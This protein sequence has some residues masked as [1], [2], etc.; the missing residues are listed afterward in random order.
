MKLGKLKWVIAIILTLALTLSSF[1]MAIAKEP[2][3]V[4]EAEVLITFTQRPG[5]EEIAFI[6]SIGGSVKQVYQYQDVIAA[7]VPVDELETLWTNPTVVSVEED[8]EVMILG[9]TTPWGVDMI[10][11]NL[12]HPYYQG[13]GVKVAILDT[14]ID[15]NHQDLTVAGDVT[16]V[17]D[18]TDGDDDN[19]H[20]TQVASIA[21]A[22][23]NNADSIGVAPGAHLYAVK[24]LDKDGYGKIS[25]IL[26]GIEWSITN[27]MQVINMSFGG[28]LNMPDTIITALDIAWN[29]GIVIVAGAGDAGNASGEGD[30]IWSPARCDSTIAVGAID[31]S[32]VRASS[33]STGPA[34][35]LVAPGP[36]TS[37]SAPHVSGVAALLIS[38]GVTDNTIIRQRLQQYADDLGVAGW[39]NQHGYGLVNAGKAVFGSG[40]APPETMHI[41]SIDMS[42]QPVGASGGIYAQATIEVFNSI[43]I[44]VRGAKVSGHWEGATDDGDK[45]L[46]VAEGKI[47]LRS[48]SLSNPI[49]GEIFT[50]V[51][52]DV[53]ETSWV[54]DSSANNETSDSIIYVIP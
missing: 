13:E 16:F 17:I 40:G 34:L 48:D 39:D 18:T 8:I 25:D 10:G 28:A 15:L 14:G 22:L 6:E 46:T 45:G 30:N 53:T 26:S 20:G 50:F 1:G 33:S 54:Y 38:S 27:G 3:P 21:A 12:V 9:Q 49:G 32:G 47:T 41:N 43:D 52:D 31:E 29:S 42:L 44:P 2:P 7:T 5:A 4:D 37:W 23:D 35:E 51:V 11:A 19:G 24:V 36:S